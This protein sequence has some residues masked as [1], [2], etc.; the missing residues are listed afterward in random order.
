M[1][2]V[3]EHLLSETNG[4]TVL[5]CAWVGGGGGPKVRGQHRP[6]LKLAGGPSSAPRASDPDSDIQNLVPR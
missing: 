1:T 3:T 2:S 4:N 6:R 5:L